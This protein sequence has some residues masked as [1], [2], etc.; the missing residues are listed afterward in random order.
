MEFI[1]NFLFWNLRYFFLF[2]RAHPLLFAFCVFIS[3]LQ[4][5]T[6]FLSCIIVL[7]FMIVDDAFDDVHTIKW[8][9]HNSGRTGKKIAQQNKK[10]EKVIISFSF[11]SIAIFMNSLTLE[12]IAWIYNIVMH[13]DIPLFLNRKR[14]QPSKTSNENVNFTKYSL[15]WWLKWTWM[16]SERKLSVLTR[17]THDTPTPKFWVIFFSVTS[18]AWRWNNLLMDIYGWR[19][20]LFACVWVCSRKLS[21]SQMAK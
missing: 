11:S 16:S 20:S 12:L 15:V 19:S 8:S 4:A 6:F 10:N 17:S 7:V 1:C 21:S 5:F 13:N 9:E 18:L 14:C 2:A 3:S